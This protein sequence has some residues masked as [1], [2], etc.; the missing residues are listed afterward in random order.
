MVGFFTSNRRTNPAKRGACSNKEG[1]KAVKTLKK[2]QT[3]HHMFCRKIKGKWFTART[4]DAASTWMLENGFDDGKCKRRTAIPLKIK[5][6]R[7]E[8]TTIKTP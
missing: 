8:P 4:I 3:K 2:K 6:L 1:K 7:P 5:Y